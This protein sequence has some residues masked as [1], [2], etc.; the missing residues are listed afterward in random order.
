MPTAR[1]TRT[2]AAPAQELWETISDPHHLPRWWP[3]V[4]RVEDVTEHAFTEVL[5][6]KSGK[7]VRADFELVDVVSPQRIVWSQQVENSPFARVLK[8]SETEI[9]LSE[10]GGGH[11]QATE[12]TIELR[13]ELHGF[14][15]GGGRRFAASAKLGGPL[16]RRA[17]NATVEEALDGLERIVVALRSWGR[18]GCAGGGGAIPATARRWASRRSSCCARRSVLPSTPRPPVALSAV[19]LPS[20]R[21]TRERAGRAAR[22][23]SAGKRCETDHAERVMH[24]AGK[25]YV[26]LVRM[27]S[28]APAG[29]PDA[30]VLPGG[31]EQVRAVLELCARSELAVVPFGGGTSV[32]GGVEPLAGRARWGDRAGHAPY[33][34]D[35]RARPRVADRDRR[36]GHAW[37]G[38]RA[39]GWRRRG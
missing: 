29:A 36:R 13:Q 30:V 33:R 22:R 35:R 38:A 4:S 3:R 11:D 19:R 6:T 2:I 8:S 26:D 24:A 32:V 5:S 27:R 20:T 7:F 28:G 17:A 18:R 34:A 31:H 39:R 25:G 16:V 37:T 12:V 21:L 14:M 9:A 23:S 15:P 1:H 10:I